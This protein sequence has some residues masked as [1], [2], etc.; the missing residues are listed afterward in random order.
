MPGSSTRVS[1]NS[2]AMKILFGHPTGN[3]NSHQ[4]ALAHVEAGRLE[5]FCVPWMPSATTLSVLSAIPGL[6]GPAGRLARRHFEPLARAP[7][8]QGRLGEIGRLLRRSHRQG[9]EELAYEANDWLMHVMARECRRGAVTAVH[10]Y[11]D[12]SLLQFEEARCLGKL[13]IYDMPIGYYPAWEKLLAALE[14]KY[15]GW[16]PAEGLPSSRW[17]RPEQKR[18]EMELADL[19]LAPSAFVRDTILQF[20]PGKQVSLAPYGVDTGF[21]R[22]LPDENRGGSLR[23]I[24]AGQCSLRKGI[25]VLIEAWRKAALPDATLML[26]GTWQLA[27]AK[28]GDLPRGVSLSG[29]I[30]REALR[31][32]L[33]RADVFVCPTFFEG[34]ALVVG[35]ALACG[36]PVITTEASGMT[37]LVDSTCGKIIP[38]GDG[39]S[40]VHALETFSENRSGLAAMKV[41]ARAKAQS[42][43]WAGYRQRVSNAVA[44]FS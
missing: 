41:A 3:P 43:T 23:F 7:K 2:K 42:C 26:V 17:V 35:E 28:R 33:T 13:C 27:E 37:D 4:A 5:A 12:C 39:E 16:L 20:H 21:W 31:S 24:Y 30:S 44:A 11:E 29:P 40:L 32:M 34:R 18:R 8:I 25:P 36:L 14:R 9:N 38:A 10:S 15:A 19:V 1:P 6:R 22:P